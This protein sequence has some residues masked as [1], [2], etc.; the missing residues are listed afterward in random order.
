MLIRIILSFIFIFFSVNMTFSAPLD[1]NLRE[2]TIVENTNYSNSILDSQFYAPLS[3]YFFAPIEYGNDGIMGIFTTIAYNIKNFFIAVAALFLMF[4]VIKLLFSSND[5]EN[6]KKWRSSI[7]WTS[8]GIFV[9]QISYNIWETLVL[10]FNSD[11]VGSSL[12]W[13]F[14]E[15]VF[16]PIVNTLQLLASLGFLFMAIWAFFIL[17]SAGGDEEKAKKSKNTI[18]YAIIGF[19]LIKI[20]EKFIT[21]IY[22]DI[23]DCNG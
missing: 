10:K 3:S 9:M 22:G 5:E 8:V 15:K 11:L 4:A 20:P 6:V 18:L 23:A 19:L 13:Q 12:G 2:I 17:V 7:I 21:A 1:N 14:W 16:A